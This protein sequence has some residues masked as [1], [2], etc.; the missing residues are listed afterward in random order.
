MTKEIRIANVEIRPAGTAQARGERK[1]EFGIWEPYPLPR[2][3][4]TSGFGFPSDFG[5][6]FSG[7]FRHSS[8]VIR[9]LFPSPPLARRSEKVAAAHPGARDASRATGRL[10][11]FAFL[12]EG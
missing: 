7:S 3:A 9:H 10:A 4:L 11:R 1:S 12:E 5:F 6:R 8:F 2:A